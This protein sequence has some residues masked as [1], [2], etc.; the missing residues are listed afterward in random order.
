MTQSFKE[1]FE[2]NDIR[3]LCKKDNAEF[4]YNKGQQ[5]RQAE[6]DE[7]QERIDSVIEYLDDCDSCCDISKLHLIEVLQGDRS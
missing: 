4:I 7:L 5:S 1:W 6:T 2:N 3:L